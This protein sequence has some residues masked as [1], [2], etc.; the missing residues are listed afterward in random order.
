MPWFKV[1]DALATHDKVLAAGNAAMGLWVRAGS[2]CAQH[3]T[4]GHVPTHAV[5]LLGNAGQA[6]ALVRAGLWLERE[7]GY[8]FHEWHDYQPT[9]AQVEEV[10][11]A[12]RKAGRIGGKASGAKRAASKAEAA[13][14]D[15]GSTFPNPRPVPT[16]PLTVVTTSSQSSSAPSGLDDDG[17]TRIKRATN[18]SDDHARRTAEFILAKAPADVRN[19]IA[20]VLAAITE[21]PAAYR[22]KRGNPKKGE[23]C[24]TH[25]GQ[26]ADACGG[27]AADR[28]AAEA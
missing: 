9:R 10:R 24:P 23:E 18:G 8:Q 15:S 2:W 4:D 1:D 13:C 14:L 28:K 5:R 16:R 22:F 11:E 6:R 20:Y 3:L 19:P 12:K 21:D 26:W 7:D 25:A 17:L 27:C